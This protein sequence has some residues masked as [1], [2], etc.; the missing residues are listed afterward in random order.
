M[1]DRP[2]IIVEVDQATDL[3]WAWLSGLAY[4][5]VIGIM[6]GAG[7]ALWWFAGH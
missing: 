3:R 6:V 4:G 7:A 5:L 1:D 2:Y